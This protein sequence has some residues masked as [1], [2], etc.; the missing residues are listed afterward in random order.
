MM[1]I[2]SSNWW[3]LYLLFYAK[4]FIKYMQKFQRYQYRLK[5]ATFIAAWIYMVGIKTQKVLEAVKS[6]YKSQNHTKNC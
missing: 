4:C 5:Q 6:S 2:I 1:F 3:L